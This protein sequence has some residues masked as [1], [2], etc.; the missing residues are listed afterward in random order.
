[1]LNL[2]LKQGAATEWLASLII[3][4]ANFNTSLPIIRVE[5]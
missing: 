2:R 3:V 4:D 1:M 5:I